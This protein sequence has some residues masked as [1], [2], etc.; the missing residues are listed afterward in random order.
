VEVADT[1]FVTD[2]P[3]PDDVAVGFAQEGDSV[4]P[5]EEGATWKAVVGLTRAADRFGFRDAEDLCAS[6]EARARCDA[7]VWLIHPL[8]AGRSLAVPRESSG[9]PGVSLAVCYARESSFPEPLTGPARTDPVTVVHELLHLFGA[10]DKYNRSLRTYAPRS[11]T[12][13]EVMR[14]SETRLS[15]L[16]VDRET[17]REIGWAGPETPTTGGGLEGPRRSSGLN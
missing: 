11:V 5:F 9:L 2:D 1:Y 13:R 6:L 3:E 10:T 15:R 7:G 14:L 17:A 4:G 12:G 8:R 16:R